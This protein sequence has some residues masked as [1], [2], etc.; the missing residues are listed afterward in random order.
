MPRYIVERTFPDGLDIPANDSGD[1]L[2][3]NIIQ[4]NAHQQVT[5]LHSY[6]SSDRKKT[7][8]LYE[9]PTPEAVRLAASHNKLPIDRITEVRI[10]DPYSHF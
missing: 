8:C 4:T 7:F 10:L 1:Q 2:R 3:M 5:W 6:V 9:G